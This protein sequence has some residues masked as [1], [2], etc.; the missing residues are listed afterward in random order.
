MSAWRPDYRDALLDKFVAPLRVPLNRRPLIGPR[1]LRWM[2]GRGRYRSEDSADRSALSVLNFRIARRSPL[3]RVRDD[4]FN[5]AA[6][7]FG[8][9]RSLSLR[10]SLDGRQDEPREVRR[11]RHELV[12]VWQLWSG[13]SLLG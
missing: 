13:H 6:H 2:I 9:S 3:D 10:F 11:D 7:D 1:S 4:A 5:D 12:G 8:R